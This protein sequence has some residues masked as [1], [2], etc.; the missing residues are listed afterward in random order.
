MQNFQDSQFRTAFAERLEGRLAGVNSSQNQLALA[1][2]VSRSTI[3]GWLRHGKL[4]DA[5][6]LARLCAV[7]DCSADWLL[8]LEAHRE[9]TNASGEVHWTENI[10]PYAQAFQRE[11]IEQGIQLFNRLLDQNITG[12][13][14]ITDYNLRYLQFALQAA[15]RSGA[16]RLTHVQRA[17]ALEQALRQKYPFLKN[18]VVAS[19][20]P[21]CD[22]TLIRAEV[23]AFLAATEV[24]TQVIRETAVGLGTGYTLLR[25]CEQSLPSIDQFK[26]THWLPLVTFIDDNESGYTANQLA[27]L[28]HIRHPGS[29][30]V[31]LPHPDLFNETHPWHLHFIEAVRLLQNVQT[32]FVTVN[33]VGRRDRTLKNHPLTDFRT[34]DYAFDS[35]YLRDKYADLPDK[36]RFGG[37]LLSYL[38][39][40]DGNIIDWDQRRVWQISLDILR[41]NSD[42]VGKVVIVAARDYKAQAVR[43]CLHS[44]LC[45]ALV[46]DDEI[47][48]TLLEAE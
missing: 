19:L 38:L 6:L 36:S 28:M 1:I 44:G 37:E 31:Y 33:G 4:P 23:V 18:I 26:G 32:M 43:T 11:H 10:P 25:M 2:G 14:I 9:K 29:Q 48:Q 20:P 21:T 5:F 22:A 39:D 47:A 40:V 17:E 7:L 35:A 8:G 41:Y 34:V 46:I 45:N 3:T 13:D 12:A 42:L 16:V 27:K 30:A 24:L 15:F